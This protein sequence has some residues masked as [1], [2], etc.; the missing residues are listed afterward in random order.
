MEALEMIEF[1][2]CLCFQC[3]DGSNEN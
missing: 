3:P 1:I 2:R